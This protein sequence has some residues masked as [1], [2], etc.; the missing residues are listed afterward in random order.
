MI[1]RLCLLICDECAREEAGPE[2]NAA[3]VRRAAENAGW[4]ARLTGVYN[5][6]VC[7]TCRNQGPNLPSPAYVRLR[8]GRT[9]HIVR[10]GKKPSIEATLISLEGK[11]ELLGIQSSPGGRTRYIPL[12]DVA[13]LHTLG[14]VTR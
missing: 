5:T 2:L 11:P 1:E 6:D 9:V 4:Q 10:G 12:A 7:P 13:E 8:I 3:E 14:R